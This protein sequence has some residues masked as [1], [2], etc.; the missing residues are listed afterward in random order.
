MQLRLTGLTMAA[1]G[2][3]GFA[4]TAASAQTI[5][6]TVT[7]P[8]INVA[9]YHKPYVA[10][11]LEK[12]G[13]TPRTIGVWYDVGKR[14]NAGTKWLRDVRLWW[15]AS[16]RTTAMPADG[17]SGATRPPGTHK[18]SFTAGRGGMP[19]LSPGKYVLVVEAAREGGGREAV[20]LPFTWSGASA[21]AGAGGKSELGAVSITVRR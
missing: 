4:A 18:Q 3:G 16:G 10:V 11:W 5:D 1:L 14:N 9:E 17:V 15:R 19:T 2:S 21:K 13:A 6:L 7:L 12:E 20:R 8:R